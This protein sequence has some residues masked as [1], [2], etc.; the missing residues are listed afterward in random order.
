MR[1]VARNTPQSGST[2]DAHTST[3][4][5][6]FRTDHVDDLRSKLIRDFD[7]IGKKR[8]WQVPLDDTLCARIGAGAAAA[9]LGISI[10]PR[11]GS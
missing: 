2:H 3:T 10:E 9:K 4:Q 1:G 8:E 11:N 5:E 7:T 6:I